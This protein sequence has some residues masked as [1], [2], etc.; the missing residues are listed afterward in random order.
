MKIKYTI[1]IFL[2]TFFVNAQ[3]KNIIEKK[4]DNSDNI[5]RL[6]EDKE[7]D[8]A[9]INAKKSLLQFDIALKSNDAQLKHFCLKKSFKTQMGD[10]HIWIRSIMYSN[11][12]KKYIGILGNEPLYAKD[13]KKDDII[14]IDIEE[15]TDWSYL[16]E[17]KSERYKLIGGFTTRVLVSRMSISERIDFDTNSGLIIE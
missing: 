16:E 15:I 6:N 1:L 12:L 13:V 10:E 3:V 17:N 9:I 14:E 11:K 8:N 5:Y 2:F 4:G 7:M